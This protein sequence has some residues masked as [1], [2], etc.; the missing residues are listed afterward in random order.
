V[1]ETDPLPSV[2][3]GWDVLQT[4]LHSHLT[5][6]G[7]VRRR[8][9]S[10]PGKRCVP[11]MTI[12]TTTI[13]TILGWMTWTLAELLEVGH[14]RVTKM[15]KVPGTEARTASLGGWPGIAHLTRRHSNGRGVHPFSPPLRLLKYSE[16]SHCSH[17][18][19]AFL[20][21]VIGTAEVAALLGVHLMMGTQV[22]G[23][24][25]V[26]LLMIGNMQVIVDQ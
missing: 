4:V 13:M 10:A 14:H 17:F 22:A 16:G 15:Q 18:R 20:F 19:E 11:C 25:L 8:A 6:P 23:L 3:A 1:S 7:T 26:D 2:D 9:R 5:Q 12:S 21:L 24:A